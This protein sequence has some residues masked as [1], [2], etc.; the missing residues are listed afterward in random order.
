MLG[1]A[2]RTY[3]DLI[4]IDFDDVGHGDPITHRYENFGVTLSCKG[5]YPNNPLVNDNNA[6]AWY[7]PNASSAGNVIGGHNLRYLLFGYCQGVAVFQNPIDFVS[8]SGTSGYFGVR[9]YDE[10]GNGLGQFSSPNLGSSQSFVTEVY[11]SGIKRIEF[12]AWSGYIT[13]FDDLTFDTSQALGFSS[14]S[15]TPTPV[16]DPAT[17]FLLGSACLI[18]FAGARKKFKK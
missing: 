11:S 10:F 18:G 5:T 9:A 3:A 7:N 1:G 8:I 13:Y 16:P 14:G 15:G 4:T 6:Y 17:V 2:L 12:G